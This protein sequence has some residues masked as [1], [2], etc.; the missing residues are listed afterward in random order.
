M[1]IIQ[2]SMFGALVSVNVPYKLEEGDFT[3]PVRLYISASTD[4]FVECDKKLLQSRTSSPLRS[5]LI[6]QLTL[7]PP[8]FP[9]GGKMSSHACLSQR[10]T[11]EHDSL[12]FQI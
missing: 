4:L 5:I 10:L 9:T 12:R 3:G 6:C 8:A 11:S 1:T 7:I 2:I